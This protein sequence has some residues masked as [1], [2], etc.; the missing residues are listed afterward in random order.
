MGFARTKDRIFAGYEMFS[1]W[2]ARRP[3]WVRKTVYAGFGGAFWAAYLFPGSSIRPTMAGLASHVGESSPARLFGGYVRRFLS[4]TEMAERVRHG[5][6]SDIAD[7][8]DIPDKARLDRL[9][10]TG[11]VFLALPHLHAS[12]AMSQCLARSYP[13]LAVVSLTRNK[14]RAAAQRALYSQLG[15]AFL[16]VRSE[17]PGT[18]ARQILRALRDGKIV[19]GTVDRIQTAPDVPFDKARDLVRATAFGSP[20]GVGAWPTRFAGKVGAHVVPAIVEQTGG[21]LRLVLGREVSPDADIV[22]STQEWVTELER[23]LKSRPQEWQF[24]VDKHWSRVLR[25]PPMA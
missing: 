10:A 11:G 22:A 17:E 7:I 14:D 15:C 2:L 1:G 5:R 3:L 21:R 23:L 24:S 19:A 6:G 9:L 25:R 12:V 16:D 8:L 18:V 13:V 4:G 20:V